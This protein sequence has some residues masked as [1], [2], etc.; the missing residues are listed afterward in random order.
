MAS[1]LY[2]SYIHPMIQG[3]I[4]L[5][6]TFW[7]MLNLGGE[8]GDSVCVLSVSDGAL[9]G[10]FCLFSDIV[11]VDNVLSDAGGDVIWPF[12]DVGDAVFWAL[13]D[14]DEFTWLMGQGSTACSAEPRTAC[15]FSAELRTTCPFS[16]TSSSGQVSSSRRK[17]KQKWKICSR[18]NKLVI[19]LNM[20][21][22]HGT[23]SIRQVYQVSINYACWIITSSIN[24]LWKTF[25]KLWIKKTF[26]KLWIKKT[27]SPLLLH[28]NA[29][30]TG[31]WK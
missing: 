14:V 24:K 12:S 10:V 5:Q 29:F 19:T 31:A 27:Y 3:Y 1:K 26:D 11:A 22:T 6:R 25:D 8:S 9:C 15:P 30:E 20:M 13:P 21:F 2:S 28:D 16:L 18:D 7:Q 17:S 4:T 23:S